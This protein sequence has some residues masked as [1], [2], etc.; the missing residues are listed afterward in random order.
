MALV[1]YQAH[2]FTCYTVPECPSDENVDENDDDEQET[3]VE[4][5]RKDHDIYGSRYSMAS[6]ETTSSSLDNN[7]LR[8]HHQHHVKYQKKFFNP[9]ASPQRTSMPLLASGIPQL[10]SFHYVNIGEIQQ[11]PSSPQ[12]GYFVPF[13]P[14]C[15]FSPPVERKRSR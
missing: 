15:Y 9:Y 8:K 3:E 12:L 11:T 4:D 6:T 13:S 7:I 14:N 2:N 5:D 1:D 10:G